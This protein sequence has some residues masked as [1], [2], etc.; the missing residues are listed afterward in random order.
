MYTA[1]TTD[2]E[3]MCKLVAAIEGITGTIDM[4]DNALC[5]R[6]QVKYCIVLQYTPPL[7][8][9]NRLYWGNYS[10]YCTT[11]NEAIFLAIIEGY[12]NEPRPVSKPSNKTDVEGDT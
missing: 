10:D 8:T 4:F 5:Y 9:G 7:P 11:P 3:E 2:R 6:L 1:T 12:G